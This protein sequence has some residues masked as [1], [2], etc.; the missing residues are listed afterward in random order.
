MESI[1]LLFGSIFCSYFYDETGLC[2]FINENVPNG[3]FVYRNPENLDFNQM[4]IQFVQIL[5]QPQLFYQPMPYMNPY[6][7]QSTSF[8]DQNT[9]IYTDPYIYGSSNPQGSKLLG[10]NAQFFVE[11]PSHFT[12]K[13]RQNEK[14]EESDAY[15]RQVDLRSEHVKS[16]ETMRAFR[17]KKRAYQVKQRNKDNSK[18]L[19]SS[20]SSISSRDIADQ[21][22]RNHNNFL[23]YPKESTDRTENLLKTNSPAISPSFE[24]SSNSVQP[25]DRPTEHLKMNGGCES[26]EGTPS[27]HTNDIKV[28][29][30]SG[31]CSEKHF[32]KVLE[33]SKSEKSS[34]IFEQES[35]ES[36]ILKLI[37]ESF[38]NDKEPKNVHSKEYLSTEDSIKS[39]FTWPNSIREIGSVVDTEDF[40]EKEQIISVSDEIGSKTLELVSNSTF[41]AQDTPKK[42]VDLQS[43]QL[44]QILNETQAEPIASNILSNGCSTVQNSS[45]CGISN[46]ISTRETELD[47]SASFSDKIP[48]S[49]SH[50]C[51]VTQF[52]VFV[53]YENE[54][55]RINPTE[56]EAKLQFKKFKTRLF[57]EFPTKSSNFKEKSSDEKPAKSIRSN[58]EDLEELLLSFE[59][60]PFCNHSADGNQFLSFLQPSTLNQP[61]NDE[62]KESIPDLKAKLIEKEILLRSFQN[63]ALP[64]NEYKSANSRKIDD[65]KVE[66]KQS[67]RFESENI[68]IDEH[69]EIVLISPQK[70]LNR[71]DEQIHCAK[72]A[73]KNKTQRF[74][75][76]QP[77]HNSETGILQYKKSAGEL[78]EQNNTFKVQQ[79]QTQISP[80]IAQEIYQH[81]VSIEAAQSSKEVEKKLKN[82]KVENSPQKK[83]QRKCASWSINGEG[84]TH[85]KPKEENLSETLNISAIKND[86][87]KAKSKFNKGAI[88]EC[89]SGDFRSL[90][91][92]NDQFGQNIVLQKSKSKTS[93]LEKRIAEKSEEMGQQPL[94]TFLKTKK[95]KSLSYNESIGQNIQELE[96]NN[97]ICS[98]RSDKLKE[99]QKQTCALVYLLVDC[100]FSIEKF[101][102]FVSTY[103]ERCDNFANFIKIKEFENRSQNLDNFIELNVK[104]IENFDK[105]TGAF[106][107]SKPYKVS[108]FFINSLIQDLRASVEKLDKSHPTVVLPLDIVRLTQETNDMIEEYTQTQINVFTD[109]SFINKESILPE[110]IYCDE[111][112]ERIPLK[113]EASTDEEEFGYYEC[114][115]GLILQVLDDSTSKK[116]PKKTIFSPKNLSYGIKH[117]NLGNLRIKSALFYKNN[118]G[119]CTYLN[120]IK[121][122]RGRYSESENYETRKI[123]IH[124]WLENDEIKLLYVF[125]EIERP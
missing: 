107:K 7:F 40:E 111:H 30:A 119:K 84:V 37:S 27:N 70:A 101:R 38:E 49:I 66:F 85:S 114:N 121:K 32:I 42:L 112:T 29:V 81:L 45:K 110:N 113:L 93:D 4:P 12:Q 74:T 105:F 108:M 23:K 65:S 62:E 83:N 33:S 79:E 44:D 51:H 115:D 86:Q 2:I 60:V 41:S 80:N 43:E 99:Q 47:V 39:K 103:S 124:E 1:F 50:D 71:A 22:S 118:D 69:T 11:N 91:G 14:R 82:K 5:E 56:N 72:V 52:P 46:Q 21:Q 92:R 94:K 78:E 106:P 90:N 20:S 77:V 67:A 96:K 55:N 28:D 8:I 54:Q 76:V 117:K 125:L 16:F 109:Q 61:E 87:P 104:Q 15:A 73:E 68:Y 59:N 6:V 19:A 25:S 123:K 63:T 35:I 36:N 17:T 100:L 122:K 75:K 18:G 10:Q 48:L 102:D 9:Q 120:F 24:L 31:F 89:S 98:L 88:T 58:D 34:E 3:E 97:K 64:G 53:D 95:A 57:F 26:V 13:E 116:S